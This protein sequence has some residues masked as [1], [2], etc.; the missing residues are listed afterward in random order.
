MSLHRVSENQFH[1]HDDRV[2]YLVRYYLQDSVAGVEPSPQVWECI[3][4][5]IVNDARTTIASGPAWHETLW[6]RLTKLPQ[7]V[8]H[9]P[10]MFEGD[11]QQMPLARVLFTELRLLND[12]V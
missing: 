9:L 7:A 6:Q 12:W 11:P 4:L 1:F 5:H 10:D 2:D 3:K 8:F